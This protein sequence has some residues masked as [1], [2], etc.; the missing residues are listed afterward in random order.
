M[1]VKAAAVSLKDHP[2]VNAS[3][4]GDFIRYNDHVHIGVAV[5]VDEGLLVPVVRFANEKPLTQ[6]G[7]EVKEFAQKA[8]EKK[9]S[10]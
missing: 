6:I 7:Q 4:Y 9:A 5:A 3:W 2:K 8:K 1:V 10:T